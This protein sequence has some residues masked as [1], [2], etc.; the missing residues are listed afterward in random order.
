MLRSRHQVKAISQVS[1]SKSTTLQEVGTEKATIWC[2]STTNVGHPR[3]MA[4]GPRRYSAAALAPVT[5][6]ARL[7]PASS[8]L[9]TPTFRVTLLCTDGTLLT[10]STSADV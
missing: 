6:T 2:S 10:Q 1:F 9:R 5:N 8:K 3:F 7:T 4:R